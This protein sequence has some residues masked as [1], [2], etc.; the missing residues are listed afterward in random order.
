[1]NEFYEIPSFLMT[2]Q[3]QGIRIAA[4]DPRWGFWYDTGTGKTLMSLEIIR[5]RGGRGL[6]ICPLGIIEN[7]W[8]EDI[9]KF[10]PDLVPSALNLW[11]E[12]R[13]KGW[14]KKLK[15]ANVVIVNF[16]SFKKYRPHLTGF[17]TV[18][19]D[20]SSKIKNHKS[21]ITKQVKAFC[22]SGGF[23]V[24]LLS[25][26]PAPNNPMEYF[27]QMS[28]IDPKMFGTSYFKFRHKYCEQFGFGGFQW[29][30]KFEKKDEFFQKISTRSTV[31]RKHDAIDLPERTDNIIDIVL[32]ADEKRHYKA[33]LKDLITEIK[34]N[35]I[36]AS[37]AVTKIMKLR[38]ITAGFI[39]DESGMVEQV[40]G[41]SKLKALKN[42]LEEIGDNQ[43]IIWHQFRHE[44]DIIANALTSGTYGIC[45]GGVSQAQKD[46][47]IRD[48]KSGR[49]QYLIAHPRTLA[50]GVTLI[51][52][53]YAIYFSLSYSH[54]EHYQSRDRIYRKGQKNAC[55]YYYLAAGK[56][57][58]RVILKALKE[59][60]HM[61]TA[62]FDFIRCSA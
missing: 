50:H 37:N 12:G 58:D 35:I 13:K 57:I 36:S 26:T 39:I 34:E 45:N 29:Q 54:E 20:E 16:E 56:T 24:Y 22:N 38:Q 1:M 33:M 4:K 40:V 42:L 46:E 25:G 6:V 48:F 9:A 7:A 28:V 15:D 53:T 5:M 59:K 52:C 23:N 27:S 44:A 51:N 3:K 31:V 43:A 14:E 47:N 41:S 55:S 49:T 62:V 2:H 19:I 8:M 61:E 18:I 30:L 32:S 17:N 11:K 60:A 21:A 10:Y